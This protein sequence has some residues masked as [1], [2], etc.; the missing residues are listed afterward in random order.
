M[1]SWGISVKAFLK[2]HSRLALHARTTLREGLLPETGLH[3]DALPSF[4]A[5]AGEYCPSALGLH[6]S[7]KTV[8]LGTTAT[9]RLKSALR[10]C[11]VELLLEDFASMGQTLSIKN[12]DDSRHSNNSL[13]KITSL[14]RQAIFGG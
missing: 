8:R 11:C 5:T 14:S 7:T 9:V 2:F 12:S 13:M 3:G 6:S 10:H 4:G 1:N